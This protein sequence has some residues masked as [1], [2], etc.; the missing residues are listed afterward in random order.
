MASKR[1]AIQLLLRVII[2][3]VCLLSFLWLFLNSDLFFTTLFSGLLCIFSIAELIFFVGYTNRELKKF[4]EA[5]RYGEHSVSF[6]SGYLGGSF[7]DLDEQFQKVVS[8]LQAA[9]ADKQSQIELLAKILENIRL[10]IIV[11]D[12]KGNIPLINNYALELL[13]IPHFRSWHSLKKRKPSFTSQLDELKFEG[14]KLIELKED[15]ITTEFYLDL[16]KIVLLGEK[17]HLISF[18]SLRNEIEQKEIEA[19]HKLIRILAHEVMNSVTPLVS[20]SE[21]IRNMLTDKDQKP[22]PPAE[23]A[24]EKIDDT[25]EALDTIVRRSKGMLNFVNDYRKLAQLPA[26]KPEIIPLSELLHDVYRLMK[27]RLEKEL[28][29]FETSIQNQKLAINADRKLIEQVLINLISNSISALENSAKKLI[30]LEA[31]ISEDVIF[32]EV[33]DNG[34][35]IEEDILP[36]IFIPFFSTREDGNGI[37]LTLSK[38]IMK[39]HSGNI[40]VRSK[41]G[42][43]ATFKL[44]F[45]R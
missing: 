13:N 37:G 39:L 35:G 16:E 38:N 12:S 20:L 17:Y 40:T 26:P 22:L 19:W 34:K 6:S 21:T 44:S 45:N 18:S 30:H 29:R 24:A 3:L 10:G 27:S 7:T 31:G 43:G 5:V 23:I 33:M 28:I 15:A 41:P 11:I 8:T 9:E 42:E 25:L 2:L 4:L 14:R 1:F 36:S 32:I